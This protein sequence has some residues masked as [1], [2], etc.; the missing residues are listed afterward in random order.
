MSKTENKPENKP[1]KKQ[2]KE[3]KKEEDSKGKKTA[4][5]KAAEKEIFVEEK[6]P[7]RL[8][9]F[10]RTDIIPG[11]TKKFNYKSALQVPK[12]NKICVNIGAGAATQD[13]K[14]IDGIL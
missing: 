1:E 7:V 5:K 13:P 14:I 9:E 6:V 10:Y 2:G 8:H 12:L 3:T 11:L 4:G